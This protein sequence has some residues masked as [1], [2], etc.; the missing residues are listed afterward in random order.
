MTT[1]VYRVKLG[2]TSPGLRDITCGE[3]RVQGP[4]DFQILRVNTNI[5][6]SEINLN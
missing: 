6:P 2:G 3:E 4:P 5:D 1:S